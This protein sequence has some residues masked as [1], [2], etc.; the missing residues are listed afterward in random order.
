MP[1][2]DLILKLVRA[3]RRNDQ[4][5]LDQ[6]IHEIIAEEREK[7]H[8]VF[9]DRLEDS[10]AITE[11]A[12]SQD[13][14]HH[15]DQQ[16]KQ[17]FFEQVPRVGLEDII[18]PPIVRETC[19]EFIEEQQRKELLQSYNLKPRHKLLLAG[20]P[21]NGKTSLAEAIAFELSIP[22]ITVRYEGIVGSYLGETS[23]RLRVLFD[24]VRNRRCVLFF[25]EFETLGKERGDEH[26][27]GEIKRVVSALLLQ[28]DA[29][30]S[31]VVVVAASNHPELLDRAV[32]RRFEL[33]L[34]LPK[35]DKKQILTWLE[36]LEKQLKTSLGIP[37]E[38]VT[39]QIHFDSFSDLEQFG[40]DL[41]RKQILYGRDSELQ[42]LV[43]KCIH[44][45]KERMKPRNEGEK[46]WRTDPS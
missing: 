20:P 23:Q 24:F 25:D 8:Q 19:G 36:R 39:E 13:F 38:K 28:I 32:W 18:L 14:S 44:Q 17:L 43:K 35:P 30:P 2:A 16:V 27:T 46:T 29:L 45:W 21:G 41:K 10:L 9:A 37:L 34:D 26:E 5:V 15:V 6:I 22:L 40:L 1:R 33:R 3:G 12:G 4:Q 42:G 7:K 11:R 31:Y